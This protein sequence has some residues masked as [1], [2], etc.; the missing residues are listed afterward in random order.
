MASVKLTTFDPEKIRMYMETNP[1][2]LAKGIKWAKRI[3]SSV[4]DDVAK[5]TAIRYAQQQCQAIW[6]N[7]SIGYIDS[8]Y[9]AFERFSENVA[10]GTEFNE[11]PPQSIG[12]WIGGKLLSMLV[13]GII[14]CIIY[15]ILALFVVK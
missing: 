5:E 9:K 1:D 15:G 10:K 14:M 12:G 3:N 2:V 11:Q 8:E 7:D 13:W 4:S 6:R